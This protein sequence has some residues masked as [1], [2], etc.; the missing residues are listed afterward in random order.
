VADGYRWVVDID[1]EKFF[2]RVNHD[3]LMGRIAQRVSDKR[4]L[5]VRR[6]INS[7]D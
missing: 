3:K 6:R 5:K 7:C 2:D 4:L 1:P